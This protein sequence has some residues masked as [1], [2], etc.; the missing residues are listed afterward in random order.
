[1]C[2]C[3][4]TALLFSQLPYPES[5]LC[6]EG[7]QDPDSHLD[8]CAK[9]LSGAIVSVHLCLSLWLSLGPNLVFVLTHPSF[10]LAQTAFV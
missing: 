10:F 6:L 9:L 4:V 1:M 5:M 2:V 8:Q 3:V 7:I